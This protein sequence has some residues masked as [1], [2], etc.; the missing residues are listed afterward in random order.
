M[1]APSPQPW[2]AQLRLLWAVWPLYA[3]V[4][5]SAGPELV[6]P[7]RGA[8]GQTPLHRYGVMGTVCRVTTVISWRSRSLPAPGAL[9]MGCVSRGWAPTVLQVRS[10]ISL[11][12]GG[13][14]RSDQRTAQSGRPSVPRVRPAAGGGGRQARSAPPPL[15]VAMDELPGL[16]GSS[17]PLRGAAQSRDSSR[18]MVGSRRR[19]CESPGHGQGSPTAQGLLSSSRHFSSV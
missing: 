14:L 17:A 1:L 5:E 2:G 15:W 9:G 18:V 16:R 12:L 19:C 13:P 7:G 6:A 10:P 4:S 8:T 11:A 3:L